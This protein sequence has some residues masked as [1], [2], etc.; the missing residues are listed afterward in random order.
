MKTQSRRRPPARRTARGA[1][2]PWI[3]AAFAAI[4]LFFLLTEHRAHLLGW[5]P[6]LLLAAC[7]L[8]HFFH[9]GHGGHGGHDRA[10]HRPTARDKPA[11]PAEEVPSKPQA[12]QAHRHH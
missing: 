10:D 7:P 4:G 5:L 8:M 11:L 2:A 12:P 6:F 1:A 9:G 3:F